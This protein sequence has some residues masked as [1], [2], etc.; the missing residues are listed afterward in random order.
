[1][2]AKKIPIDQEP[3]FRSP[4]LDPEQDQQRTRQLMVAARTLTVNA[5]RDGSLT[6]GQSPYIEPAKIEGPRTA[7]GSTTL[8]F[9]GGEAIH[10]AVD[11]VVPQKDIF[12]SANQT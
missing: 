6:V 12:R 4:G 3:I 2:P 5:L 1:M 11:M 10:R 9:I 8:E 7:F